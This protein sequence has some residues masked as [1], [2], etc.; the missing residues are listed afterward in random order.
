MKGTMSAATVHKQYNE[1]V[2]AF[3]RLIADPA[4]RARF[5][6]EADGYFRRCALGV[7]QADNASSI[8]PRHVEFYNAIYTNGSSAPSALYWEVAT[9]VAGFDQFQPPAFF[10]RLR[11]YDRLTHSRLSRTFIDQ[12]TLLLLLFAAVDDVVSEPEAGFVNACSD[13][14][15][16]LCGG[17][18]GDRP[19]LKADEFVTRPQTSA[20]PEEEPAPVEDKPL[21][22]PD[23]DQSWTPCAAWSG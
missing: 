23:L 4:L 21:P 7:W 22:P 9:G 11:E 18:E 12:L 10:D 16:A 13:L 5:D 6:G 19:A 1:V 20:P 14:L 2:S 8:T 15:L 3:R 17:L